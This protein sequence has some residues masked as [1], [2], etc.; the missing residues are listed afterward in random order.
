MNDPVK[1]DIY[2]LAKK[3]WDY[4]HMN[5]GLEK[6]DCLLVLGSHD[7]RVAVWGA[8]LFHLGWAPIMIV[9]GGMAHKGDLLE[10]GWDRPEAEVFCEAMTDLGVPADRMILEARSTNTGEN[11]RLVKTL[12]SERG[13]DFQRFIVVTKPYMERRAFAT[14]RKEWP[15]KAVI[16]TSPGISFEDYLEGEDSKEDMISIMVGDLQRIMVYPER[17]YQIPQDVPEEVREAFNKLIDAGYNKHLIE[18]NKR[19]SR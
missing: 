2:A 9:S 13:L 14:A 1:E 12:L 3:L 10:T 15:G 19:E 7:L 8:E 16:V 18:G 4:H 5:Q 11:F 17:G 6:A